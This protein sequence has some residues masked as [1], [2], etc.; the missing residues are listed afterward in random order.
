MDRARRAGFT[1]LIVVVMVVAA[2]GPG[3]RRSAGCG[4]HLA[5]IDARRLGGADRRGIGIR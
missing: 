1:A 5:A 2:G 4:G 3:G